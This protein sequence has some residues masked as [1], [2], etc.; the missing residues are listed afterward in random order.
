MSNKIVLLFA[1]IMMVFGCSK[2]EIKNEQ[3]QKSIAFKKFQKALIQNK[4][5]IQKVA[6]RSDVEI[7]QIERL[8]AENPTTIDTVVQNFS[9]PE[10][11]MD[12][13][14]ASTEFLS[15]YGTMIDTLQQYYG[16]TTDSR[17]ILSAIIVYSGDNTVILDE[18]MTGQE[19][20]A[21]EVGQCVLEAFGITMIGDWLAGKLAQVT[22]TA[23]VSTVAKVVARH[24]SAIGWA[25]GAY[26]FV[27]CMMEEYQD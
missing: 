18:E 3:T 2:K 25:W 5:D 14:S 11:L 9:V 15:Y 26:H 27:N 10:E 23:I 24:V 20:T 6:L 8:T 22:A 12:L 19:L 7:N 21:R 17:I 16:D 13:Y 1:L 4:A